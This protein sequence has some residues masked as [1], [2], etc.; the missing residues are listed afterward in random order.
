MMI[1]II[2]TKVMKIVKVLVI[3]GKE[4]TV[5]AEVVVIMVVVVVVV[6]VAIIIYDRGGHD[7]RGGQ[8]KGVIIRQ[9]SIG[10]ITEKDSY[11]GPKADFCPYIQ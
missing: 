4:I 3:A 6:V 2:M 9:A 7:G 11:D 8:T 5:T 1:I 10:H